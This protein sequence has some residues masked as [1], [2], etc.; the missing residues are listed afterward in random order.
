MDVNF[1]FSA[2]MYVNFSYPFMILFSLD[3]T[4]VLKLAFVCKEILL[5]VLP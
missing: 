5:A 1:V 3:L 2:E 4:I